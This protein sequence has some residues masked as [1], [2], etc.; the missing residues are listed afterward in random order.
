MGRP[1]RIEYP[2]ALYHITSRGNERKN[3]FLEDADKITFLEILE[4]YHTRFNILI[5]S[6]VLMDNHYH[7][8]VETPK[9]DLVKVMHGI[10]GRYTGYFNRKYRRSGHLFQGRYKGIL[11][12][13]DAYLLQLSRYVHLNP[14]RAR[15]VERPEQYSWSS[16]PEYIGKSREC[17]W[18]EYSWILSTFGTDLKTAKKK[19]Q[20]YIEE[21]LHTD[22]GSPT[23]DLY[24]QIMLGGKDFIEKV[25]RMLKGKSLSSEI[26]ERKRLES[27]TTPDD[28][29]KIVA[30][31]FGVDKKE[32]NYKGK[33]NTARKAAIYFMQR[34]A[35]LGNAEVGELFGGI[36]YS[37]VSK[38]SARLR[39]DMAKDKYLSE[40]I[41]RIDS[42]FKT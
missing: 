10:N 16:Y 22:T 26:A 39:K 41:Q 28:V 13:K 17:E 42:H 2:G 18:V 30:E 1:L 37:A 12:D 11:V 38:A 4:D 8:I 31:V 21:G 5:H 27:N 35:G 24:G 25:K 3:I 7:V 32:I 23:K 15:I 33:A 14:V 34:Y 19:Y 9:G 6:Y 20:Q 40:I 29:I 36:H